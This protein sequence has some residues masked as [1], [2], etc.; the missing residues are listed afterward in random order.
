M[1][2]IENVRGGSGGQTYRRSAH[3]PSRSH[4]QQPSAVVQTSRARKDIH[5]VD[6]QP[7]FLHDSLTNGKQLSFRPL[8]D[9]E[10]GLPDELTNEF[11][12]ALEEA[13]LLDK[14]WNALLRE[15]EDIASSPAMKI[16]RQIRD[17][18]R[19]QLDLPPPRRQARSIS[20]WAR[21]NGIEPSFD[22]PQ[23]VADEDREPKHIDSEIQTLLLPDEL[24]GKMAGVMDHARTAQ[25]EIGVN[26]LHLAIGF[27]KSSKRR[28]P[29]SPC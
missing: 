22:L 26:L 2:R 5:V 21:L 3:P 11:L 8:P 15:E 18:V 13:R 9:P 24:Q 29:K 19:A 16:D 28:Q 12:M 6:E 7:D 17:K 4:Q 20:D 14:A 27:L 1:R 23:P 25:Q 10:N